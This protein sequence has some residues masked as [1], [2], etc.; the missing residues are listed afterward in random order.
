[1]ATTVRIDWKKFRLD[2]VNTVSNVK[3]TI[4]GLN[5]LAFRNGEKKFSLVFV[6][7][8]RRLTFRV[9]LLRFLRCDMYELNQSVSFRKSVSMSGSEKY[10]GCVFVLGTVAM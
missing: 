8:I 4:P 6:K 1:M 3:S 10:P 9:F 7:K 5:T 2:R